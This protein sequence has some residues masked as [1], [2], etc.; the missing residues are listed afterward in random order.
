MMN[1]FKDRFL[2]KY[3]I[4]LSLEGQGWVEKLRTHP[5]LRHGPAHPLRRRGTGRTPEMVESFKKFYMIFRYP[6]VPV[7]KN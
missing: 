1:H 7:A 5:Y 6:D 3:E 4:F 2:N